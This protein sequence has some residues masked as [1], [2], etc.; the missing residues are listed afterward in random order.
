MYIKIKNFKKFLMI[1]A[2]IL[3]AGINY[4]TYV[5]ADSG[6]SVCDK[7]I[8]ADCDGLT[9]SE[10]TVYGTDAEKAD[11]DGD[12]YSDGVEVKSGYDPKKPAPGDKLGTMGGATDAGEKVQTS[13]TDTFSSDFQAFVNS[14]SDGA[15]TT[16][17]V[18]SFVDSQL[19]DKLGDS[20][21]FEGLPEMDE[22][23][24]LILNQDYP[25]LSEEKK[26]EKMRED[27]GAY[28]TKVAYVLISNA[29]E[30]IETSD[31]AEKMKQ[32]FAD[33]LKMMSDP[34]YDGQYFYDLAKKVELSIDQLQQIEVPQ[35]MVELHVKFLRL[36]KGLLVL[37]DTPSTTGDPMARIATVSKAATFF[38]LYSDFFENDLKNYLDQLK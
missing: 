19:S 23:Q 26:K 8:D 28:L 35:S 4:L 22:S 16:S 17:D 32:E 7:S 12:G 21:T 38:N 5:K 31:D 9:D 34:N 24:I 18:N 10:E 1:A 2:C 15:I 27:A 36:A 3:F 33:N 13:I 25:G 14:K 37:R 20:V 29:P 11:T 30:A 6:N